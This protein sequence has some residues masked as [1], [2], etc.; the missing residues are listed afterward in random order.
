VRG[1]S[2]VYMLPEA[3]LTSP[4]QNMG[5]LMFMN[6]QTY[7]ET[8]LAINFVIYLSSEEGRHGP[9]VLDVHLAN[10]Q[11]LKDYNRTF[12]TVTGRKNLFLKWRRR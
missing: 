10:A 3:L 12:I 4:V 1:A 2:P 9:H 5:P 11:T 8:K 7:L 6:P